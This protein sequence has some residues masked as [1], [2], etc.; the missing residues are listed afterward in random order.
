MVYSSTVGDNKKFTYH[1][2][3]TLVILYSNCGFYDW[4]IYKTMALWS[5]IMMPAGLNHAQH[6]L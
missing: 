5:N 6:G 4:A 3:K 2:L 1:F